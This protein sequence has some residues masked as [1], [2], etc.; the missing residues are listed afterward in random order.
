MSLLRSP[1]R[2]AP[3][4]LARPVKLSRTTRARARTGQP[5]GPDRDQGRH[6]RTALAV[7][8]LVALTL[9]A[10][11]ATGRPNSAVEPLRLG[12]AEVFGPLEAGADAAVRPVTDLAALLVRSRE[13]QADNTRL[14]DENAGLRAEL[15]TGEVDRA[16]LAEYDALAGI[17]DR[18]GFELV[19]AEVVAIGP[20]QAFRRTVTIN[21]GTADGIRADRTVVN[22][23]GLVGRVLRA[24][25]HTATVLLVIDAGSVVGGR[26]DRSM[27]LGFLRGNGSLGADGRLVLDLVDP[28]SVPVSGDTI[29]T[30]GSRGGSPYVPG[31]PVGTVGEVQAKAGDQSVT[32]TVEPFADMTSLDV[33]GVVTGARQPRGTSSAERGGAQ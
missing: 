5:L 31:V 32:A 2:G 7:S 15:A 21:A 11:D 8:V 1:S 20:A 24:G 29:V 23:A 18:T 25:R 33:V 4:S 26:L 27:E 28:D 13:L 6:A 22:A 16:R 3:T 14:T 19:N 10:V 9:M 17:T 30:W 12:A